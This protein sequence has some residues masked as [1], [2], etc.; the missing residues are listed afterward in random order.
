VDAL[1]HLPAAEIAAAL[2]QLVDSFTAGLRQSDDQTAVVIKRTSAST[3]SDTVT[4]QG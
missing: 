1:A 3:E 2:Y 4:N